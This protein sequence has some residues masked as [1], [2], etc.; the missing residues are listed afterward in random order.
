MAKKMTIAEKFAEVIRKAQANEPLTAE[1]ITFLT[2]R[3][4]QAEKK[5]ADRKPT[6][7]Q[8]ENE[9]IKTT[10]L[11]FMETDKQYTITDIQ[12]G[13]GLPT[14][15]RTSALVRQLV[16]ADLVIRS[17]VKGRAYFTKAE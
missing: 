13:V 16:K 5:S 9:G 11:D 15:Q 14:N 3:K 10:I 17:E 1:D 12:K 2:E 8:T 7:K 6:A 4:A